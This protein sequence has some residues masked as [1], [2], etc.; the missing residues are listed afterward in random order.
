MM[1]LKTA[2]KMSSKKVFL[3]FLFTSLLLSSC[4]HFVSFYDSTTYKNLTDLKA[5]VVL[6]YEA[7]EKDNSGAN[8]EPEMNHLQL[9]IAQAYE[10]EKGKTKNDDTMTQLEEIKSIFNRS[11]KLLK[12]Q[13]QLTPDYI[14]NKKEN[15]IK[16]FDIAIKTEK[17]KIEK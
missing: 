7:L 17:S 10:Y 5:E 12:E 3:A 16:A 14:K 15:M 13:G 9:A 4:V 1:S 11:I 6:F 2:P 8:L